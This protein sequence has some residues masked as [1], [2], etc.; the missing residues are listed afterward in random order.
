MPTYEMP[1]PAREAFEGMASSGGPA[2]ENLYQTIKQTLASDCAEVM[3]RNGM[4]ASVRIFDKI[5]KDN[6]PADISEESYR[7]AL[8]ARFALDLPDRVNAT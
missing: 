6:K 8:L 7:R 1:A 4:L 2:M 3:Q 5:V